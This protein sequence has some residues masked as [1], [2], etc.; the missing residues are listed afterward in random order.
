VVVIAQ[1][2]SSCRATRGRRDGRGSY[3]PSMAPG[4]LPAR[5]RC[6]VWLVGSPDFDQV[7]SKLGRQ[8]ARTT[9][10]VNGDFSKF[11]VHFHTTFT[12]SDPNGVGG[13][14]ER[15]D[16][17]RR[18]GQGARRSRTGGGCAAGTAGCWL[19]RRVKA[20]AL[21]RH[22]V[23]RGLWCTT[24]ARAGGSRASPRGDS[25]R[26]AARGLHGGATGAPLRGERRQGGGG[27]AS[28]LGGLGG[29][30]AGGGGRR[31]ADGEKKQGRGN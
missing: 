14:V 22:G 3:A 7:R 28:W 6:L 17:A 2:A 27:Y 30:G 25:P 9:P 31:R 12:T 24:P 18:T 23:S 26:Q 11:F 29:W 21:R 13:Y 4:H 19:A 15:Q 10:I 1:L 8:K 20:G 5:A 16:W